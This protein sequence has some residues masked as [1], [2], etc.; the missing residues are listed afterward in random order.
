[1]ADLYENSTWAWDGQVRS[2]RNNQYWFAQTFT[3]QITHDITSVIL[4]L[5]R[6]TG[7]LPGE[8]I[9]SIR[10]TTAEKPSGDDLCVGT[11]NGNT[12]NEL[13]GLETPPTEREI[14]FDTNPTLEAG[15]KYAIVVRALDGDYTNILYWLAATS[16]VYDDGDQC[17]SSGG[18]NWTLYDDRELWF[19]EYGDLTAEAPTAPTDP[20]PE[21]NA[22]GVDFSD[23]TLSWVTGDN[24]ETFNVYIGKTDDLTLVSS[25]QAGVSYVT[26]LSELETI[27]GVSPIDQKIYWQVDA[28][29]ES[30][31]TVA[32][33]EWNFDPRPAQTTVPSPAHGATDIKLST[34]PLSYTVGDPVNIR[35]KIQGGAYTEIAEDEDVLSWVTPYVILNIRDYN[36]ALATGY[37]SPVAGD[38]IYDDTDSYTVVYVVRGDLI[39]V[40]YQAKLYAFRTSGPGAKSPGGV[41]INGVAPDIEDPQAVRVTLN[42]QWHFHDDVEQIYLPPDTTFVWRV[43]ATNNFG[44][45]TGI[46]WEFTTQALKIPKVSYVLI[47]GESGA[48]PYDYPPGEEGVDWNWTGENNM[49]SIRRLIAAANGK[50]WIEDI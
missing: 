34:T 27:F 38:V 19:K 1:M 5:G 26:T 39:N 21:N 23:F 15:L 30:G 24:T 50:I 43:D 22:T 33:N 35:L 29:N 28:T 2:V 41:L 3:P 9:V 25:A 8:V 11:T 48:G 47:P 42:D 31:T 37:R 16:S 12:V 40:E 10:E 18:V 49:V 7:D 17:H 44:T 14:T 20:N 6:P 4:A 45:T 36:P 13:V 32:G 46:E